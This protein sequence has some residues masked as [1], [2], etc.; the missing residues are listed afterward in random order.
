MDYRIKDIT[1]RNIQVHKNAVIRD[2]PK[3]GFIIFTGENSAG[4]SAILGLIIAIFSTE[5]KEADMRRNYVNYNEDVGYVKIVFY[6]GLTLE[7]QIN[8]ENRG[9]SYYRFIWEDTGKE[10][11][12]S[13]SDANLKEYVQ[14]FLNIHSYKTESL[15]Y[16]K[17]FGNKHLCIETTPKETYSILKGSFKDVKVEQSLDVMNSKLKEFRTSL[18]TLKS[19]IQGKEELLNQ[20]IIPVEDMKADLERMKYARELSLIIEQPIVIEKEMNINA[21]PRPDAGLI[22]ILE[23]EVFVESIKEI[24]NINY[25]KNLVTILEQVIVEEEPLKEPADL[26]DLMK[27]LNIIEKPITVEKPCIESI[28]KLLSYAKMVCPECER[29]FL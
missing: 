12:I 4:K 11:L 29:S 3:N 20:S 22:Q 21:R 6:E 2:L 10:Y 28:D 24:N 18:L 27:L 8:V 5:I 7:V 26:T 1:V 16:H 25:D 15:N 9:A 23:K 17:T 13:F 19:Q 14:S